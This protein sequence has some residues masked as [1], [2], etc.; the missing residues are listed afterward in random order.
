MT[1]TRIAYEWAPHAKPGD[2]ARAILSPVY[3]EEPETPSLTDEQLAFLEEL[4]GPAHIAIVQCHGR[5]IVLMPEHVFA[6][7]SIGAGGRNISPKCGGP[8]N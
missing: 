3:A 1:R 6:R 8:M 7:L 2:V 5:R 4:I